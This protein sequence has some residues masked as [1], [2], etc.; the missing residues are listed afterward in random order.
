M[1]FSKCLITAIFLAALPLCGQKPVPQPGRQLP[2][3]I[4]PVKPAG[5]P[6]GAAMERFYGKWGGRSTY[7]N[8]LFSNFK[9]TRLRGFDYTGNITRRDPSKVIRVHGAYYVW[10]TRR[11]TDQPPIGRNK[12]TDTIPGT[13]W[14]LADIWYAT[15]KDGFVW[16]E[17][18][19]AVRRPEK[20]EIGWRSLCTP[21]IL[22]WNGKYYL[23][24]Q[25]YSDLRLG[26]CPAKVAVAD[27]PDGP[28]KLIHDPVIE[29]S[30]NG[31]W[32]TAINDPYPLAYKGK[33]YLYYK[34]GITAADPNLQYEMAQGL[35]IADNP[36]GPFR[37]SRL[38]P[39]LN[40][41]HETGLFPFQEGIAA[42]LS[43]N[44]PEMST[45]QYAPDGVNFEIA[46][47]V[48]FPPIAPGPY[49]PDAFAD[50]GNGRGITWGLCHANPKGGGSKNS[51][52]LLRFDCDLSLDIH[53][54]FMKKNNLRPPPEFYYWFSLP[55]RDLERIQRQARKAPDTILFRRPAR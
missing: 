8:E 47:V 10:Y 33:V 9:Y 4:P 36:L 17:K 35:A 16:E 40:S 2:A 45:I 27:S 43:L 7:G 21:D 52:V 22:V 25:A 1:S 18:G 50:N 51:A 31:G 3:K 13:D 38:N 42:I 23:Y 32:D 29:P 20:P 34:S 6:L 55:Q 49:V 41:G 26:D 12:A 46:A 11:K 48:N 39:V 28:W 15:S 30:R 19:P 53:N 5:V 37:R 24:F 44:G 54:P 14:D